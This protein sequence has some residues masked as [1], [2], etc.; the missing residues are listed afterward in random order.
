MGNPIG[1]DAKALQDCPAG[2]AYVVG[3]V[4]TGDEIEIIPLAM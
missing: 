3:G 2:G 4:G 1:G